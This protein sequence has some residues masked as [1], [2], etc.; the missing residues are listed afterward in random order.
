MSYLVCEEC[1][2]YYE[3]RPGELPADFD[4]NCECGGNLKFKSS[5]NFEEE[6]KFLQ[7]STVGRKMETHIDVKEAAFFSVKVV[8]KIFLV[9]CGILAAIALFPFGILGLIFIIFYLFFDKK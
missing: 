7:E 2:K 8:L 1:N 4:D 3:L 5:L 6:D 9:F